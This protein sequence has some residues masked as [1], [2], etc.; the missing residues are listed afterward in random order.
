MGWWKSG[1]VTAPAEFL[2]IIGVKQATAR[3]RGDAMLGYA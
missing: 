1:G 2:H 3:H